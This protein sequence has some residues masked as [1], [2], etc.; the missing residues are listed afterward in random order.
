M[1]SKPL[2]L[3]LHS[4]AVAGPAQFLLGCA[5]AAEAGA[6]PAAP[7]TVTVAPVEVRNIA[8]TTEFTGRLGAI[9][10][11]EIRPRVSGY[12]D[13]VHF[14]SGQLVK[15]GDQLFTIDARY[16]EAAWS[17]TEAEVV[18]AQVRLQNADKEAERAAQLLESRAISAEESESRTARQAEARAALLAAEAARETAKLDIEYAEVVAPVDGRVG[19]ALVT[20]GNFVSGV[21]GGN[22]LLT[23]IVS[24]D[25]MYV[26]I[27]VDE[28]SLLGLQKLMRENALP[29][30]EQ[31]RVKVEMGLA[32]EEGYS[33]AGV[34]ESLGNS[35]DPG[36]GSILM[37]ILVPNP[38]GMLLPGLFARV[39]VPTTPKRDT[40]L[41][42]PRAI[43]TDQS[44]KF[45]YVVGEDSTARRR[46]IDI[47][48]LLDGLR[49]VRDGLKPGDRIIVNGLQ[50]VRPGSPVTP[51]TEKS[52]EAPAR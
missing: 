9:D 12:L 45:V 16:Y 35:L 25:P 38:D 48:P 22:T 2:T 23:T 42:N 39:R 4:L 51:E 18:Q 3:L 5:P 15:R 7:P 46:T 29:H 17:A 41:V 31:G 36:T 27:D 24:V 44:Q 34:V 37:R 32:D 8:E 11:V 52:A 21:P 6:Q 33:R 49:I 1:Q 10:D 40:I 13:H 50:R 47:G 19:R 28:N 26:Y 14:Q 20:P 43:G 30:D